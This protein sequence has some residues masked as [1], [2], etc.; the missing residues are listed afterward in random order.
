MDVLKR[1]SGC[2]E[3]WY[4]DNMCQKEH[5]HHTHKMQC[6]YLSKKKVLIN[7]KHDETTCLVCKVEASVGKE[8]MSKESNPILPCTMSRANRELMNID[9]SFYEDLPFCA[10]AEMTGQFHTKVEAT[11]ATFMRILVKMKMT[12][13]SLWLVPP[14]ALL[15]ESMY[16]VLWKERLAHV[17][18][19]L[20]YKK[21]GSLEGQLIFDRIDP[22]FLKTIAEKMSAIGDIRRRLVAESMGIIAEEFHSLFKPWKILEVLTAL[23]CEGHTNIAMNAADCV[24]L[25]GVPEEVGRIRTTLVKFNKMRDKD[26]ILLRVGLVPYFSLV[27]D[28]LYEG[29]PVQLCYVC[30]EEVLVRKAVAGAVS[31]VIPGDPVLVLGQTVTF[32]LCGRETCNKHINEDSFKSQVSGLFELYTRLCA[33]HMQEVCDYCGKLNHK[34]KG[35]RCAGCLTK[36]YCGVECQVKDTYHLQVKCEKGEKRKKKRSY[37]SRKEEGVK[38]VQKRVG[39]GGV[40][41]L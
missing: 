37:S 14:T 20:T 32:S 5:W 33:E 2:R 23:L 28:G 39:V 7:A 21:P 22:E 19:V 17:D 18:G 30:S 41:A 9:E 26:L 15:A 34:A 8:E 29:N 11:I 6:K 13:H 25:V 24:G 31:P 10:L 40:N 12:K 36:L 4:C 38:F 1:C 35:H 3:V 16:K 27:A